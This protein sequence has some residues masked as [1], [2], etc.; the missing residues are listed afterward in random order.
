MFTVLT[1]W[2]VFTLFT[3]AVFVMF[4]SNTP[5]ARLFTVTSKLK[6]VVPGFTP[7]SVSSPAGTVTLI[8]FLKFSSVYV[9]FVIPFILTLPSA[10]VVPS[11]IVSIMV[12]GPSAKPVFLTVTVYVIVSPSTT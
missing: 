10:N 11:G 1:T 2:F 12:T 3:L 5:C 6:V 7:E 8:P 4:L 9:S